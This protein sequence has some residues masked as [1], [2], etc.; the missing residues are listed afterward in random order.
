MCMCVCVRESRIVELP[1]IRRSSIFGLTS[2]TR[3]LGSDGVSGRMRLARRTSFLLCPVAFLCA[4]FQQDCQVAALTH[5]HTHTYRSLVPTRPR[6]IPMRLSGAS[7]A[8]VSII[9]N[10]HTHAVACTREEDA[11]SL[12]RCAR[13]VQAAVYALHIQNGGG[14]GFAAS[15]VHFSRRGKLR[16]AP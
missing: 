16:R 3:A 9:H 2:G 10:A 7:C 13:H 6:C 14:G 4:N 5:T 12:C 15:N 8:N 11:R 1:I